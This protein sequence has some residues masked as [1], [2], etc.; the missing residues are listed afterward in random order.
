MPEAYQIGEVV[1]LSVKT[2]DLDS[3]LADPGAITLKVK[4]PTGTV[5][6]YTQPI[7]VRDSVG[8]YHAD[9][10]LVAA[11]QWAYRWEL[12]TPNAGAAEG[13]IHVN[14]SYVL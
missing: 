14:K 3:L 2:L 8:I 13:L 7:V 6:P 4:S 9:I 1:R 11:G 12:T 10:E 5:T